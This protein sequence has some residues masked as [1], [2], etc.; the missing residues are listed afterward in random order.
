MIDRDA[1]VARAE[2]LAAAGEREGAA[3][4]LYR[5]AASSDDPSA[6]PLLDQALALVAE[7]RCDRL[8]GS[9]AA[10]AAEL[11]FEA[12]DVTGGA[13]AS[14]EAEAC[15]QRAG[16][17]RGF[18]AVW[19]ARALRA[20]RTGDPLAGLTMTQWML[21]WLDELG[22]P[23]PRVWLRLF[24]AEHLLA[25][26]ATEAAVAYALDVLELRDADASARLLAAELLARALVGLDRRDDGVRAALAELERAGG[27]D[28]MRGRLYRTVALVLGDSDPA[29]AQACH[30]A[31]EAFTRAPAPMPTGRALVSPLLA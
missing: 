16:D 1:L 5:A 26:D 19:V 31:A 6:A 18:V 20:L 2:L 11:A 8:R 12:G 30:A 27:D 15:F 9:I 3:W 17:A 21:P 14:V 23:A 10:L 13:A 28:A 4:A 22:E 25:F 24:A 7:L 29:L